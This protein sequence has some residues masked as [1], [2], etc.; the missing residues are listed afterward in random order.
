MSGGC[1]NTGPGRMPFSNRSHTITFDDSLMVLGNIYHMA[2][3]VQKGHRRNNYKQ[4]ITL[5]KPA[6]KFNIRYTHHF[7]YRGTVT[8]FSQ[9]VKSQKICFDQ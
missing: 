8:K 6:P 9:N 2:L 1:F 4:K 7:T 5:A 3:V